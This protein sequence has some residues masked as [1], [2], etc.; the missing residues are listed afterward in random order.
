MTMETSDLQAAVTADLKKKQQY[1]A[2]ALVVVGIVALVAFVVLVM[3]YP[4]EHKTAED[5]EE[6]VPVVT[7]FDGVSLTAK[8]SIVYDLKTGAVLYGK[9]EEAQLPLASLTKL[10]TMYAAAD[11]LAAS[12]PVRISAASLAEEGD[13]GFVEGESFAFEDLARFALVSSSNDAASAIA[14][15]ASAERASTRTQL[16]ASAVQAAGLTQTYAVNGTG[17]DESG[18]TS[19]GYGSAHDV[20]LLAGAL[21]KKAP[22]IAAATTHSGVTVMS[23]AGR[24]LSAKNTNPEAETVPGALLSKT[25]FTDL[26]GGNLA[27]VFDAAIDHPIAIVVLGSTREGRFSDVDRL[28]ARTMTQLAA[29][30]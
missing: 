26:A 5:T 24:P 20:A 7:A 19:G 2:G 16:L 18:S 4:V 29:Q 23:L 28:L 25:G 1:Q 14:E 22:E 17:L 21:I 12:S 15:A 6:V 3:Q 8:A 30:P 10:L 27:V 9:N 11:V 13:S